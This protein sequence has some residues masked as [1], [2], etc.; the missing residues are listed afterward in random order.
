MASSVGVGSP[1]RRSEQRGRGQP[2]DAIEALSRIEAAISSSMS[3]EGWAMV[4]WKYYWRKRG[5][6]LVC[7]RYYRWTVPLTRLMSYRIV[8]PF[9]LVSPHAVKP[10]RCTLK[11][12]HRCRFPLYA[13]HCLQ[14]ARR[15]ST[16]GPPNFVSVL[17]GGGE[18]PST[19]VAVYGAACSPRSW[20]QSYSVSHMTNQALIGLI[21]SLDRGMDASVVA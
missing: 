10:R 17:P 20:W 13:P 2:H 16:S 9:R 4:T 3:P 8:Q 11:F 14:T 6:T 1:M 21:T 18:L 19:A 7:V 5:S 12:S 15:S